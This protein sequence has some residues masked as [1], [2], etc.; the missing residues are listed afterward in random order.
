MLSLIIRHQFSIYSKILTARLPPL[1]F[2]FALAVK[3]SAPSV[4]GTNQ[5]I[6]QVGPLPL[7]IYLI[8]FPIV[9]TTSYK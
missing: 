2:R 6:S 4:T 1:T 9:V 3:A 5:G 8:V 7:L